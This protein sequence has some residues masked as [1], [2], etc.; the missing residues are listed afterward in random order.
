MRE[1]GQAPLPHGT[2]EQFDFASLSSI[3]ERQ[4]KEPASLA[5]V[6]EASNF[7]LLVPPGVGQS[8]MAVALALRSMENG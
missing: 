6:A 3:E 7:L 1:D 8:H 4:V 2:L 5:F